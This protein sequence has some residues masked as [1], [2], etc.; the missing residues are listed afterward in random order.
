MRQS[1][2]DW[3]AIGATRDQ[4]ARRVALERMS[5]MR[6]MAGFARLLLAHLV[7]GLLHLGADGDLALGQ[8]GLEGGDPARRHVLVLF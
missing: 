4:P 5:R 3:Q 6:A 7:E 2:R 1:P 8:S